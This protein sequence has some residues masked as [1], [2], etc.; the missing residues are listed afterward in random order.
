MI[1]AAFTDRLGP[2]FTLDVAFTVPSSGVTALLGASGS[3]KTS[4]LRAL[5]GLDRRQGT[6]SVDGEVW[7]SATAFVPAHRRRIGYVPQT[8]GLLP[9]LTVGGNLDYASRRAGAVGDRADIVART[10][11]ASLL[12]RHPKSLS[13]GEA[14][15][16]SVARALLGQPQM[17]LMD[18][19]L[20]ALDT[21]ARATMLDLLEGVFAAAAIPVF[22]VTHDAAEAE[23]L[24][25]R[26]IR[27]DRGRVVA[28]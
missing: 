26:T 20:S 22:Y 24:A 4:V 18:E 21:A 16:A 19:P 11:I 6:L 27:L 28:V 1:E 12:D 10:G 13:G 17:L 23:R 7:Q 2:D 25:A 9:H 8:Q 3:G 14:Q 5:A 15:R